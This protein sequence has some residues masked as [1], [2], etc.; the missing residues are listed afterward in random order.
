VPE[1]G[2][3]IAVVRRRSDYTSWL[4]TATSST[5][6]TAPAQPKSPT[7]VGSFLHLIEADADGTVIAKNE[8]TLTSTTVATNYNYVAA[9]FAARDEFAVAYTTPA[10][11]SSPISHRTGAGVVHRLA[12][13][14]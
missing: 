13:A 12:E 11:S 7:P 6:R 3:D 4:S 1:S 14:T 5:A 2:D 8:Q 10:P 9:Y